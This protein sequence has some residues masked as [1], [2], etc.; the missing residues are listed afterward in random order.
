MGKKAKRK[1][2]VDEETLTIDDFEVGEAYWCEA[3]E[4]G[5]VVTEAKKS[6][7]TGIYTDG[8]EGFWKKADLEKVSELSRDE[9]KKVKK[10]VA[11]ALEKEEEEEAEKKKARAGKAFGG[12]TVDVTKFEDMTIGEILKAG[13]I[14]DLSA[15]KPT[16]FMGPLWATI[17]ENKAFG[18]AKKKKHKK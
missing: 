1:E 7:I 4:A 18:E 16:Q 2:K 10:Q 15:V 11:A 14:K 5:F 12:K 6:G 17:K 8:F 3:E 13:G 9:A